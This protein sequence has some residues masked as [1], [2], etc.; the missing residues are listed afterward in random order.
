M[1]AS[2]RTSLNNIRSDDRALQIKAFS[3]LLE[4]TEKPVEWAYEV[5]DE[6]LEELTHKDN[7]VRAI[8]AQVLVN[9]AKSDPDIARDTR[10]YGKLDNIQG[11]GNC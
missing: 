11:L 4:E 3:E 9:L 10:G 5:W 1:D 6:L 2:L 7:R 8:S